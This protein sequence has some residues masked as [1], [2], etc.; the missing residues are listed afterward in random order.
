MEALLKLKSD[1]APETGVPQGSLLAPLLIYC[2]PLLWL[3]SWLHLHQV[4]VR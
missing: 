4:S 2:P 3:T 1:E